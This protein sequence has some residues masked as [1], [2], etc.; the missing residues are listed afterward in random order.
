MRNITSRATKQALLPEAYCYFS[1]TGMEGVGC[2]PKC[3]SF[4][5]YG[6]NN[7]SGLPLLLEKVTILQ[8]I[9]CQQME[10]ANQFE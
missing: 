4:N 7:H 5:T 3:S 6:A 9:V 10:D 1:A 8:S 2:F